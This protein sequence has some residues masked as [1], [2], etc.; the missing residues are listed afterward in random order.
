LVLLCNGQ[1]IIMM[2][3]SAVRFGI[4]LLEFYYSDISGTC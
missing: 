2:L 3:T 4:P 1:F